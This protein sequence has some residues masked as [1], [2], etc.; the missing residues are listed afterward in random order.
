MLIQF[1]EQ[2]IGNFIVPSFTLSEGELVVIKLPEGQDLFDMTRE[3]NSIL[4]NI[5]NTEV[6][7]VDIPLKYAGHFLK[8]HSFLETLF[9]TTVGKWFRKNANQKNSV[10]NKVYNDFDW[11]TPKTK[12]IKIPR[13][14]LRMISI[15]STLSWTTNIVFDLVGVDPAGGQKIY[16]MV[17]EVV[18]NGGAAILYGRCYEFKNDCT[19]FI[20]AQPIASNQI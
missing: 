18:K 6:A 20:E 10:F 1:K 2:Q 17:K 12:L 4:T 15:Y 8:L 5:G 3:L 7:V 14:P 11:L 16:A 19:L 13:T 9:P